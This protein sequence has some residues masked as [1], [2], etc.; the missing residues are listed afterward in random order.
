MASCGSSF[1]APTMNATYFHHSYLRVCAISSA[2]LLF[3]HACGPLTNACAS[4]GPLAKL[5]YPLPTPKDVTTSHRRRSVR[6][7]G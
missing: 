1:P 4:A 5:P 3:Q 7:S 2:R 6:H